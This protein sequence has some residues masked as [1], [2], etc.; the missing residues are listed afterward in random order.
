ML[1]RGFLDSSQSLYT[2]SSSPLKTL[3]SCIYDLYGVWFSLY[4]EIVLL[5]H[6]NPWA[7]CCSVRFGMPLRTDRKWFCP[8]RCIRN[9]CVCAVH[10]PSIL[11]LSLGLYEHMGPRCGYCIGRQ[12][13]HFYFSYVMLLR[14]SGSGSWF[15]PWLIYAQQ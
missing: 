10:R 12:R 4:S 2:L 11:I 8:T 9:S 5:N 1:L 6:G 7:G 3:Q 15:K 13:S 14:S